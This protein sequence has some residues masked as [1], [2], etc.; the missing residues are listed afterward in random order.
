MTFSTKPTILFDLSHNEMLSPI[1]SAENEYADLIK[2]LENLNLELIKNETSEITEELLQKVKVLIIGNPVNDFFSMAE[3]ETI[4]AYVRQGGSL[5]LISEYGGDYLQKTNLNDISA[6]HFDI[7]FEKNI[8]KESNDINESGSSII[9]IQSFPKH[10]ITAQMRE[11]IIGGSCSLMINDNA[12]SLLELDENAWSEKYDESNDEWNEE[13]HKE[14]YIVA[15]CIEFGRGK[16]GAIGDI[17]LFSDDPNYGA[18]K[19]DNR[20]FITNLFNWL[21]KPIEDKDA[22]FWALKKLGTLEI[23]LKNTNDKINNIIETISFLEKRISRIESNIALM[24]KEKD[25][26]I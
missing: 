24:R 25:I 26:R 4:L 3:I 23:Q 2:L 16:V 17:D 1:K 6:K 22:I 11:I 5:L 18:N 15:A 14:K 7:L 13:D 9:S 10:E 19:L 8:I 20:K 21:L 12:F